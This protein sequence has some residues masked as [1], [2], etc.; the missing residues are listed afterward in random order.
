MALKSGG[1]TGK[2]LPCEMYDKINYMCRRFM[3]R[4]GR[5][6][7]DYNFIVD[8]EAFKTVTSAFLEKAPVFR[9]AVVWHPISPYWRV[10]D[11]NIDDIV[12]TETPENLT[13]AKQKFFLREIPLDSNIQINIAL[14]YS[15]GR[16]SICFIWN[17]MCMDG[18]GYKSFWS[19]F[20]RNYTD[21]VTKGINPANFSDGSRSYTAVYSDFNKKDKAKAKR[22]FTVHSVKDKHKFPFTPECGNSD[23]VIVTREI[24][25][26]IFGAAKET[27]KKAEATVND[28][29]VASYMDAYGKITGMG[30]DESLNVSCAVDLRRYIKDLSRIGYTNHVSFIHC[31]VARKGA[32]IHET[33]RYVSEVN[34]K[35]KKDPFMGLH[36]LPLLNFGYK[37]MI[38]LQ[39]EPVIKMFYNNPFLAV[40]NVGA[41]D[42]KA[43]SIC[44]NEPCGVF[45]AGAA[46]N[47]PYA[48]LTALTLNDCL[49]LSMS[50]RGNDEDRKILERFFDEIEKSITELSRQQMPAPRTKAEEW[51]KDNAKW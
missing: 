7:L 19:D 32:A 39:A 33:L 43:L 51:K 50:V 11:Y 23:V 14:F 15:E 21:Y 30:A 10:S 49:F 37:S 41:L 46:K 27:S 25:K 2:K 4:M 40:S 1:I 47:K 16:T 22:L 35:T 12:T 48:M 36:G 5:V 34:E 8:A 20:C 18:G 24:G 13:K 6:E 42:A 17:H 9:S 29:L 26:E 45:V 44:G 38:Y 28:M 3:D 31:A